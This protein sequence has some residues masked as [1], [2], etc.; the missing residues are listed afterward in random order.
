LALRVGSSFSHFFPITEGTLP[1]IQT[2]FRIR[3]EM[4]KARQLNLQAAFV[5]HLQLMSCLVS[6]R[7]FTWQQVPRYNVYT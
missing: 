1:Y 4:N 7:D 3:S 6:R 2:A 5:N